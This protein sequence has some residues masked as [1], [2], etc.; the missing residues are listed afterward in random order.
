MNKEGFSLTL[1]PIIAV[2]LFSGLFLVM[3]SAAIVGK[4]QGEPGGLFGGGAA[5]G[6]CSEVPEP[7]K[8]I[9]AQAGAKFQVQPAFIAAI[10][11]GGEHGN[12]W[13]NAD[14]PWATSPA[15]AQGPFQFIP[16]TWQ[17]NKQDGNGDGIMDVQNI[18]DASFG[19]AHLLAN[20]GA[21]GMT[22]DTNSLQNAAS[23]YNS[24]R[25][26]A[27]A[28]RLGIQE[29]LKYVPQV[30]TAFNKFYCPA[31]AG[32]GSIIQVA[33]QELAAGVHED[34]LGSNGGD[35][36]DKYFPSSVH[37]VPWCAYFATWVLRQAGFNKVPQIGSSQELYNWFV[38][39]EVGIPAATARTT[40]SPQSGDIVVWNVGEA[41]GH[42]GIIISVN[43]QNFTTIEG[44]VNNRVGQ[45]DHTLAEQD[46]TGFGRLK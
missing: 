20:I 35:G 39:N 31:G 28:Q 37:D 21:G 6:L 8:T 30:M 19:A 32:G 12:S 43:G 40:S 45:R 18:R 41:S 23:K 3:L 11:Y 22:T 36:V 14:G 10:F 17:S 33:Q 13:P 24:G 5:G 9:F 25:S 26:W 16:S 42:T 44:N 15:G 27:E 38:K 34:P 1:I 46:L 2:I 4:Q 29:T 7:Y